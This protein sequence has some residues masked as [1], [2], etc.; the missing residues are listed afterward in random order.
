M[1]AEAWFDVHM[2][3]KDLRLALDLARAGGVT[4]PSTA[5]A[6]EM[7]TAA[8]GLGL[9]RY[10]FAVVFDVLAGMSG[11]GPSRKAAEPAGGT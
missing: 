3:Q 1:P 9:A 7:L 10:D 2:M 6:H 5:L 8:D 11:L 4:L